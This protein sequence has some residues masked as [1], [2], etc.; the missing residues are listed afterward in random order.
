MDLYLYSLDFTANT[1]SVNPLRFVPF[2]LSTAEVRIIVGICRT[3][4][5]HWLKR[6][7]RHILFGNNKIYGKE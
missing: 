3:E 7:V 6:L 2:G 4:C 5:I 1:W